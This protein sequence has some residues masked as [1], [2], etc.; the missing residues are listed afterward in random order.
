[1][2]DDIFSWKDEINQYNFFCVEDYNEILLVSALL[3]PLKILTILSIIKIWKMHVKDDILFN[4]YY[5]FWYDDIIMMR[6]WL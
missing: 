4:I 1:M 2:I 5:M 3:F 6:W